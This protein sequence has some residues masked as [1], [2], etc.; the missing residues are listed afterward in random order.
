[1]GPKLRFSGLRVQFINLQKWTLE[2]TANRRIFLSNIH[3]ERR[4][5]QYLLDELAA[6]ARG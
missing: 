6:R 1:M 4:N 5:F 2:N 3:V